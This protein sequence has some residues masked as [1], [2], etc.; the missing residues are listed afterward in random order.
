V[1]E[2]LIEQNFEVEGRL[3]LTE[4]EIRQKIKK[5]IPNVEPQEIESMEKAERNLILNQLKSLGLSI[6]EIERATGI[7]R[8]IVAKS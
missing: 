7:S 5:N 2:R 8:G 4:E 6:R 1:H 3:K